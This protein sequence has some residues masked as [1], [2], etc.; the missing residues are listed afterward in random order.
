MSGYERRRGGS[1]ERRVKQSG[2]D[3]RPCRERGRQS[4]EAKWRDEAGNPP[5]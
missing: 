4:Q 1:D 5:V 3:L 2:Q